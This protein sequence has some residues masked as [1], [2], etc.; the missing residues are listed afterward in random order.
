MIKLNQAQPTPHRNHRIAP[1]QRGQKEWTPLQ[2]N[3][4]NCST[5]P[6]GHKAVT[7]TTT[8][9][10]NLEGRANNWQWLYLQ[11]CT[12]SPDAAQ[13]PCKPLWSWVKCTH[14]TR[15]TILARDETCNS[16]S[17]V[18]RCRTF[19]FTSP[20]DIQ[21][22]RGL[23]HSSAIITL[24]VIIYVPQRASSLAGMGHN[25]EARK[26]IYRCT[27]PTFH[28]KRVRKVQNQIIRLFGKSIHA[29]CFD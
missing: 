5:L 7:A 2:V 24:S 4:H 26:Y 1:T 15:S 18:T 12:A 27:I 29:K 13:N 16:R 20:R 21:Y 10:L 8:S 9:I 3:K 22:W 6:G 23:Q 11:R 28:Y 25:P 17:R 14:G 19:C